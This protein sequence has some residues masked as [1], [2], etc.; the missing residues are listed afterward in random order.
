[1]TVGI[2]RAYRPLTWPNAVQSGLPA[3]WRTAP[4][5]SRQGEAR[6][7][8]ADLRGGS[9]IRLSSDHVQKRDAPEFAHTFG[10]IKEPGARPLVCPQVRASARTR[11]QDFVRTHKVARADAQAHRRARHPA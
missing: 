1:M 6:A 9:A 4:P 7:W 3:V 5:R 2:Q 11:A 8:P 10:M